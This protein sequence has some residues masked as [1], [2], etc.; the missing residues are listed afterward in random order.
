MVLR[1]PGTHARASRRDSARP[2]GT[3]MWG[4]WEDMLS[5]RALESLR[6]L[7]DR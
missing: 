3:D 2:R 4:L 7:L 6:G 1:L 5:E